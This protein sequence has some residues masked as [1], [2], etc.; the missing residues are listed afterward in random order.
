MQLRTILI[1]ALTLTIACGP[2]PSGET[3]SPN[4]NRVTIAPTQQQLERAAR[5]FAELREGYLEWYFEAH[6]VRATELG[7][8]AYDGRFPAMDRA[9]IQRRIETL[10][11]WLAD[12]EQIRFA[13]VRNDDR[14]DYAVLRSGI[15][16]ELLELEESRAWA[17]DPGVYTQLIGRG[18]ASVLERD[19]APFA[20]RA[21]SLRAR[22]T[23]ARA[24]LDAVPDNVRR[25]PRIWTEMA[26]TEAR[27][28]LDYLETDLPAEVRAQ[29]GDSV[30]ATLDEARTMLV[31]RLR[32]HIDWMASDLLPRSSGTYR[33]GRYMLERR[34]LYSDH[35]SLSLDELERLNTAAINDYRERIAEVAASIDP[36]RT[37]REVLDSISGIGP[38][39]DELLDRAGASVTAVR[40][41]V[42]ESG[43]V[44]VPNPAVPTVRESPPYTRTVFSSLDAPGP[45]ESA[46]L[47]AYLN[48][49]NVRPSWDEER[50]EQHMSYF[51]DAGLTVTALHET[52]P[53]RY[54]QRQY[55]RDLSE[56]RRVLTTESFTAGWAHYAAEMA[57][58]QGVTDD[59][60]VRL[61]QLRR[62]LQ[63]HARWYAV[64]LLHALDE[65]LDQVVEMFTEIAYFEEI[66]ARQEVLRATRDPGVMADA[67]GRMQIEELREDYQDFLTEQGREFSLAE[68]HAR[69]LRLG[70][71][72]PLA[73]EVMISRE[74]S[75][76]RR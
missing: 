35:I 37:P 27:G 61:E 2:S 11:E 19:F 16:S 51:S 34:L 6:P 48:L 74:P 75:G 9:G 49:T 28:L 17:N 15:R 32:A 45:F 25:P 31:E 65:P 68:F 47:A 21:E 4:P 33:L 70:L 64:L 62:A 63:R 67:L 8:H 12:L 22:L 53:G 66:P 57:V 54:V 52:F 26:L 38:T 42:V 29:H 58:E 23:G 1:V 24:L 71:P 44:E 76:P 18:L 40:D 72:F 30:P 5:E 56:L 14:Y 55:A 39:P 73:R 59:P 46:D 36:D 41:W 10:L 43:V 50:A 60:A 69:L 20:E 3:R 13:F 7:V